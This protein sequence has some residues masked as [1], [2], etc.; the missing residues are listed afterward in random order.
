MAFTTALGKVLLMFL[1]AL[2]L[3]PKVRILF[4]V[5]SMLVFFFTS[6]INIEAQNYHPKCHGD[7][8]PVGRT[9][10][11]EVCENLANQ[12][13]AVCPAESCSKEDK[14]PVV[15]EKLA[16]LRACLLARQTVTSVCFPI[17]TKPDDGHPAQERQVK[18]QIDKC[19]TQANRVVC[20]ACYPGYE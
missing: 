17:P 13:D 9:C 8:I 16:K 1:Y 2:L 3:T 5:V 10:S 18:K 11:E 19:L 15:Q 20:S 7:P 6:A 4:P 12:K 14:C